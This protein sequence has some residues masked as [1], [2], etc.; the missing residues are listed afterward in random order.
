MAIIHGRP[1]AEKQFM[2]RFPKE[3]GGIEISCYEDIAT[4]EEILNEEYSKKY[5]EFWKGVPAKLAVMKKEAE[6]LRLRASADRSKVSAYLQMM[7]K[8]ESAERCPDD[9]MDS[10]L[11]HL[12]HESAVPQMLEETSDHK[13]CVGERRVLEYLSELPDDFHVICDVKP[14]FDRGEAVFYFPDDV[15]RG[16]IESQQV[17]FAV[18]GPTGVFT[19]EA[20]NP[21]IYQAEGNPKD[22]YT[23]N[24]NQDNSWNFYLQAIRESQAINY[25]LRREG[26]ATTAAKPILSGPMCM[27]DSTL[28][29]YPDVIKTAPHQVPEK[30]RS[31]EEDVI[32]ENGI[33]EIVEVLVSAMQD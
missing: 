31:A 27:H 23:R 1:G 7:N 28:S 5:E 6:V 29:G 13:G 10:D 25:L 12:F 18:A 3:L 16:F 17:D 11:V 9:L 2:K 33:V 32:V 8:I 24:S 22:I 20:K 15:P 4:A 30:I 19:I 14:T 26:V 21:T